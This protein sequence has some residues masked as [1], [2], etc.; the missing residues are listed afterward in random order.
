MQ[1][2]ITTC[3]FPNSAADFAEKYVMLC[4]AYEH[5]PCRVK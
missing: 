1:N 3:K 4:R 2:V 5:G